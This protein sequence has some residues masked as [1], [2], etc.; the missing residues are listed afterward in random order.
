[1][2]P[3]KNYRCGEC[4]CLHD[5]HSDAAT[6]C[7]Q[8]EEVFLCDLCGSNFDNEDDAAK[9][10]VPDTPEELAIKEMRYLEAQGQQR[11]YLLCMKNHF[12]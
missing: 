2:N 10:C 8:P 12:F 1:M 5:F 9:C 11:L 6:C 4:G 3:I 7:I